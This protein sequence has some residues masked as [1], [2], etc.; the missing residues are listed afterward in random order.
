M[1][2]FGSL[3]P[4]LPENFASCSIWNAESTTPIRSGCRS[5][6]SAPLPTWSQVFLFSGCLVWDHNSGHSSPTFPA[7]RRTSVTEEALESKS[8]SHCLQ[9]EPIPSLPIIPCLF[10]YTPFHCN[11]WG[12]GWPQPPSLHYP[13][14]Q[15][16]Q[17]TEWGRVPGKQRHVTQTVTQI[18]NPDIKYSLHIPEH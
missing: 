18:G 11:K 13:I 12:R 5:E 2:G 8:T 9:Q 14:T 10:Y 15:L 6:H 7:S 3:P 16:R 17:S 1:P 4:D